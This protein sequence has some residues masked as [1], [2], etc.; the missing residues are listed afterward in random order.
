MPT[1][2]NSFKEEVRRV[3]IAIR[4]ND[5]RKVQFLFMNSTK[6]KNN[7]LKLKITVL[8]YFDI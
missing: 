7:I 5:I 1:Y 8:L 4:M 6:K 2:I 3:Y